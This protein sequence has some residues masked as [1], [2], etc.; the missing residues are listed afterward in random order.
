MDSFLNKKFK[1]SLQERI[2][3]SHK[4]RAVCKFYV[5]FR[6]KREYERYLRSPDSC[7]L[8]TLK[9]IYSGNRCFIIG[10]GP[11]LQAK[12]LEKLKKEYTFAV[13]RIYEI[14]DQTE[15]RPSFY[16]AV[17]PKFL[18]ENYNSLKKYELGHMFLRI[19]EKA[20]LDYPINKMTRIF[21]SGD[22]YFD[23]YQKKYNIWSACVNS[24]VSNYFNVAGTVIFGAIQMALYMGF[25]EIYLLGVDFNYAVTRDAEGRIYEDR[26]VK[27]YFNDKNYNSELNYETALHVYKITKE[28]CDNHGILIRNATRGGKLEVFERIDF[29]GIIANKKSDLTSDNNF[30]ICD[31][32]MEK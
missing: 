7:Y 30:S 19:S 24:D 31:I 2:K 14:F 23:V 21:T 13:N 10:N 20:R 6:K 8:K 18:K 32:R 16:M 29:D 4:V 17:D 5:D 22:C 1:I 26:N 25:S 15:W 11:S 27:D 28:Y 12:D 9:G 3:D